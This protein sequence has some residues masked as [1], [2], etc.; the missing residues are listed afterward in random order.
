[1]DAGDANN[2]SVRLNVASGILTF[3]FDTDV[4]FPNLQVDGNGSA[5]IS[6]Q[7]TLSDIN[8]ALARGI[9]HDL[10]FFF[11]GTTTLTVVSNDNG[12][13]GSPGPLT[14]T[15]TLTVTV[16][17]DV[18]DPPIN[19]LPA[20]FSTN[21]TTIVL[22]AAN[23]NNLSVSDIDAGNA[24]NFQVT[25]TASS[26]TLALLNT[27]G[28]SA[29]GTGTPASP[30]QL[31]GRLSNINAALAL[32]LGLTVPG[33]FLGATT[34]TMIS[35]D[36][37]NTG[38]GGVQTDTD[39]MRITVVDVDVNDPP[40]N[41]LPADYVSDQVFTLSQFNG[42]AIVISDPDAGNANNFRVTLEVS[43]VRWSL[44]TRLVLQLPA[45]D[46]LLSR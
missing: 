14:D 7:G 18:N 40:V 34:L 24:G 36:A 28:I 3:T 29:A 11:L 8:A 4:N 44:L 39:S 26:G 22:S 10:L 32:G 27:A 38:T 13:T 46:R 41:H 23:G 30:L 25:L 43:S 15:D 16:A 2:F 6:L 12:N 45:T 31:T 20:N 21:G 37:G 9:R 5:A 42:N 35:N 1:M 33:G 19:S 17:N